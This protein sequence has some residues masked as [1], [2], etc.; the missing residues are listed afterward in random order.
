[1]SQ[2]HMSQAQTPSI[3]Q[4]RTSS[5]SGG[6]GECVQVRVEFEETDA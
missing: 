1:M 5:W 6:E 2:G 3:Q 4:W